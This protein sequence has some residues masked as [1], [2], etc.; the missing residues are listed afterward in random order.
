MT[1]PERQ[2]AILRQCVRQIARSNRSI[3]GFMV[4]SNL[5]GGRQPIPAD[6]RQ[7][8]PGVSITDPCLGWEATRR[9]ILEAH[10]VLREIRR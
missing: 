6:L 5:E 7:L 3:V 2:P 10:A 1:R 8:K 4:E 9:M